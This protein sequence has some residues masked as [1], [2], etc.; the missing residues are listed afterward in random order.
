MGKASERRFNKEKLLF[1]VALAALAGTAFFLLETRPEGLAEASPITRT[2]APG[3]YPSRPAVTDPSEPAEVRPTP[4]MPVSERLPPPIARGG[5]A[6]DGTRGGR[7]GGSDGNQVRGGGGPVI[8][9]DP[10]LVLEYVG[11]VSACGQ[12]CGLLRG[13]QGV[14]LRVQAGDVLETWGCSVAAIADQSIVLRAKNGRI[15]E[16]RNSRCPKLDSNEAPLRD[17]QR[18]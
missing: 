3:A 8:P 17:S 15:H 10:D 2:P 12:T 4:F 9:R 7:E 14:Q 6:D 11:I 18:Q 5:R 13:P 1:L 16:L